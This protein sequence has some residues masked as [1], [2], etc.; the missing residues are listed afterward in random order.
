MASFS[1]ALSL[2]GIEQMT[3]MTRLVAPCRAADAFKAVGSD[4]LSQAG[5]L[6]FGVLQLGVDTV[7]WTTGMVWQQQQGVSGWGPIPPLPEA[8]PRP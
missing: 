6:A 2:F 3:Q 1:W 5:D 8:D 4:L 7:S